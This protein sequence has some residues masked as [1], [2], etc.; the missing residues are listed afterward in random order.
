MGRKTAGWERSYVQGAGD[1]SAASAAATATVEV[2]SAAVK[3]INKGNVAKFKFP[4]SE[5]VND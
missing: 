5:G 4:A 2:N 3:G 1:A